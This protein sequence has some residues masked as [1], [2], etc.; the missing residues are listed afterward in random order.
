M[1]NINILLYAIF[2]I[3]I[4]YSGFIEKVKVFTVII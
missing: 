4:L 3:Y 2:V 1:E